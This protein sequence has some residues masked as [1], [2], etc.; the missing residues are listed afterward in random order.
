VL[1][2]LLSVNELR[3]AGDLLTGQGPSE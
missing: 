2:N 3:D 1:P